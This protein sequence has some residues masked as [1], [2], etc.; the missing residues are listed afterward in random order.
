MVSKELLCGSCH[1]WYSVAYERRHAMHMCPRCGSNVVVATRDVDTTPTG[2]IVTNTDTYP[3]PLGAAPTLLE[4][5]RDEAQRR[6]KSHS[7]WLAVVD[8][9]TRRWLH[10]VNESE[11]A[12]DDDRIML[13]VNRERVALG[14]VPLTDEDI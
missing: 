6:R 4:S 12:R 5:L 1:C 11:A 7:Q 14:L 9:I 13:E 3:R 10:D 8:R 2:F